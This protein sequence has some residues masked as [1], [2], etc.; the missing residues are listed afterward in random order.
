LD[1]I[2]I[3]I[4]SRVNSALTGIP[5]Q[6]TLRDLREYLQEKLTAE[7]FLGKQPLEVLIN[8]KTFTGTLSMD[9][10]TNCMKELRNAHIVIILYNGEAGWTIS[11]NASANGICHEEAMV[12]MNEFSDMSYILDLRDFSTLPADGDASAANESYSRDISGSF[13]TMV[14]IT[15][16]NFEQLKSRTLEQVE[17]YVLTAIG[18]A[19]AAQKMLVAGSSTFGAT[20]D[21]SK[22]TYAE[23][24]ILLEQKMKEV[25]EPMAAFKRVL[26]SYHGIPDNMSV[27]DARNMIGR[28]F[29]YEHTAIKG[30][31]FTS[32]IIHLVAVYGNVTEGQAKGLV[33]YPDI[34]VIKAP[35]GL[36]LWEKNMHIQ[37]FFLKSCINPQTVKTRYSEVSNWLNASREQAN[38]IKRAGCRYAILDTI[39]KVNDTNAPA[40]E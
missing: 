28:P 31:G 4:S 9:A 23:R 24:K 18:K 8:E 40:D 14:R 5:G 17:Q 11:D 13:P 33:G 1:T 16:Q 39:N 2:K 35:F 32:G 7:T 26:R 12:A 15:A 19:M 37:L 25:F 36:Y 10:F 6:Y 27:A 21:W 20:L 3:F 34:T 22:L 30:S 38:I 29:L